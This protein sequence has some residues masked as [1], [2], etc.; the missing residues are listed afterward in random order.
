MFV[1]GTATALLILI[2]ML[3]FLPT[4]A[5]AMEL[6]IGG[7]QIIL[8]GPVVGDEPEKVRE[9]L[10]SSP[11]IDTVI[12]RNSPGGD[13]R[14]VRA[15]DAVGQA[16]AQGSAPASCAADAQCRE[17]H[18]QPIIAVVELSQSSWL[19]DDHCRAQARKIC[20]QS[21]WR[22]ST[23]SGAFTTSE[24]LVFFTLSKGRDSRIFQA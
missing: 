18:R 16:A 11:I 3:E 8:S 7:N 13:D 15:S 19:D 5:P 9:A 2:M 6:K 17:A 12:L 21:R 4:R 14:L 22:R 23:S 10:V 1:R 20:E 24:Q